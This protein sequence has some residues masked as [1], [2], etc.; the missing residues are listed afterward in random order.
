MAAETARAAVVFVQQLKDQTWIANA[1]YAGRT[2]TDGGPDEPVMLRRLSAR[3]S[4]LP[5]AGE[6]QI[7]KLSRIVQGGQREDT[8]IEFAKLTG[9]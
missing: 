3:L 6:P 7:V 2:I 1:A 5:E 4:A 9:D 8:E